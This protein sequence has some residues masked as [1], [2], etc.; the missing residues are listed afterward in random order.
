MRVTVADRFAFTTSSMSLLAIIGKWLSCHG[1]LGCMSMATHLNS[2]LPF[3]TPAPDV[4]TVI[5]H[6]VMGIVC[7]DHI[8]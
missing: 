1:N 8:G 6:R 5:F 7:F 4:V 3:P 2:S